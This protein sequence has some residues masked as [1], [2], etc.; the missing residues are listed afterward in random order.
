[1]TP[2]GRIG[3]YCKVCRHPGGRLMRTKMNAAQAARIAADLGLTFCRATW[4]RHQGHG[5]DPGGTSRGKPGW[6][7]ICRH[8]NAA[9]LDRQLRRSYVTTSTDAWKL[10]GSRFARATYYKHVAHVAGRET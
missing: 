3:T 5:V 4:Y 10:L 6:C 9:R 2:R 1:M 8:P 7:S